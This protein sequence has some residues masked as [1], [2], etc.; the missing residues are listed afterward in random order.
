MTTTA[1]RSALLRAVLEAPENCLARLVYADRLEEGGD[2][3]QAEFI[4]L[5]CRPLPRAHAAGA[6]A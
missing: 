3:L 6:P 4:R 2:V 1:D 5:S